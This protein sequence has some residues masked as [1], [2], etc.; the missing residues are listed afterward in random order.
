MK[1][2]ILST[3]LF[4]SLLSKGQNKAIDSVLNK[5]TSG[6]IPYISVDSLSKYKNAILLDAREIEEYNVS[7][8]KNAIHIG[9]LNPDFIK[10]KS[11]DKTKNIV[12]Y[13]SI[14]I[15]SEEIAIKLK[16]KGFNKVY[17]LYGGIF[18]WKDSGYA[19]F[20]IRENE[21]HKVHTFSKKWSE[22]LNTGDKV[23]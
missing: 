4:I 12:V 3:F 11:I 8:L 15:R 17:N 22:Y 13:C 2:L 7:H 20:D 14:G 9:Y 6:E 1:N 16:N 19:V 10:L 21:T 18:A 23:Y 5:Y